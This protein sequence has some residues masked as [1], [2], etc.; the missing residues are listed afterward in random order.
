MLCLA[1]SI[2]LRLEK[3]H[4]TTSFVNSKQFPDTDS[5]RIKKNSLYTS[6]TLLEH[7]ESFVFEKKAF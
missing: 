6:V 1:T 5:K 4:I 3:N 2:Q 7:S